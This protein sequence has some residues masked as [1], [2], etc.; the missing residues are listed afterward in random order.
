MLVRRLLLLGAAWLAAADA[1]AQPEACL[2]L[3]AAIERAGPRAPEVAAAE[4][5]LAA[6]EA[7][8]VEARSLRRPQLTSFGRSRSG[9]T[10]LTDNRLENQAGLQ[11]SQRIVDFGDSRLAIEAAEH[12]RERLEYDVD[13]QRS[14][15]AYTVAAAMLD[16][17]EAARLMAVISERRAY[18]TR[19]QD[20]IE[21]L[22]AQGGATRADRA[23]VA[24]QRAEAEADMLEL[25]SREERA[26]SRLT[27]YLGESVTVCDGRRNPTVFADPLADLATVDD[28][29][30]AALSANPEIGALR[31]AVRSQDARRER[32]RR[33]R[34]PIVN[35]VGIASYVYDDIGEDWEVRDSLGVDVTVPIYTGNSLGARV[36]RETARL[37]VQESELR[38]LQREMREQAEI[39]F[40]RSI[41]LQAQL[42]R[43]GVVAESQAIYFDAIEGEFNAGLGTL[44]D[45]VEA[46]LDFERAQI[47]VVAIEFALLREQLDLLLLTDRLSPGSFN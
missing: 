16:A 45:L 23:Q 44:P 21:T 33:S 7:D 32:E 42:A 19:Q 41:S 1:F 4:A 39:A 27:A 37:E 22:F 6:G 36:D 40:R 47:D 14:V 20:A 17:Q 15:A 10:G 24:A 46:R 8:L 11:L 25:R 31:S 34:L 9:D 12:E 28:A 2:S 38:V 35:L 30:D 3:E 18:F 26:L 43:R 29:V 13:R 5:R